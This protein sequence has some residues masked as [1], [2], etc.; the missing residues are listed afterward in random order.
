MRA[1]RPEWFSNRDPLN[2]K[3]NEIL[4]LGC[5]L[6]LPEKDSENRLVVIIR[7][8]A[9]NPRKHS[10]NDVFK[11]CKMLL[12]LVLAED[13][14]VSIYGVS[15]IFD[16]DKVQLGHALQLNPPLIKR[17]VQSWENYSCRPKRLEFVNS[18]IH[19]NVVLNLFRSFMNSK[20]KQRLSINK[21]APVNHSIPMS[22]LP[23]DL[24]GHGFSYAELTEHWLGKAIER[25][26]WFL[27]MEQYKSIKE[28]KNQNKRGV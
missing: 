18:P 19:V 4:R 2:D 25:R 3:V 20:M 23:K 7:T 13:E 22:V 14:S 17:S 12:D 8:A 27:E 26:S 21:G 11:V 10:Q 1:E 16:M 5:F 6:P 15:A 28:N 24:G 9:H